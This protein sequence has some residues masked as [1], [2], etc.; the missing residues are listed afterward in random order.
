[1]INYIKYVIYL[2]VLI[3]ISPVFAGSYDDFFRAVKQDRPAV[4]NELLRRG[5]DPNT[6]NPDGQPGLLLALQEPSLGVIDELLSSP[7]TRAEVRNP[8]DENALMLAALKGLAKVCQRLIE[9]GADINKPGWTPLHYA[10]T[11]GHMD[12]VRLLLEQSAYIDAASPNGS[13]PLMMAAMYG[14]SDV[15]KVL[16]EAGA[17]PALKNDLNLSAHDFAEMAKQAHS[18]NLIATFLQA[19]GNLNPQKLAH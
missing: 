10:A 15:V 6:P 5:F 19:H 1:M 14:N 3:D 18:A 2:I 11:G 16:L 8:A 12:I 9:R 17:D 4:I 7:Q 13:T